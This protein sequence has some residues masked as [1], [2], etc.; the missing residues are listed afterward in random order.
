MRGEIASDGDQDMACLA[1]VSGLQLVI[2]LDASLKHLVGVELGILAEKGLPESLDQEGIVAPGGKVAV[3]QRACGVHLLLAV[4]QI[5]ELI[6]Q[7]L[8]RNAVWLHIALGNPSR[9]N[10]EE[11]IK[12]EAHGAVE[13]AP[14][15]L[16]RRRALEALVK[17]V[18]VAECME[19]GDPVAE[20]VT[21]VET[22]DANRSSVG[23]GPG[24]CRE[25][26]TISQ[27][28]DEAVH[29]S[30][31]IISE[32]DAGQRLESTPA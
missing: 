6:E 22:C 26:G 23:D 4:E 1:W 18:G 12:I 21:G 8:G 20:L 7:S 30:L 5:K 2:L 28:C 10:I 11:T 16:W 29:N 24:E 14:C 19:Y 17:G 3:H 32:E 31:G 15:G 9:G 25:R 13:D 27:G